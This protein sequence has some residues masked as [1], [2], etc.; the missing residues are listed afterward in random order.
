MRSFE[1]GQPGSR[2][3]GAESPLRSRKN[4]RYRTHLIDRAMG[5]PRAGVPRQPSHANSQPSEL[6]PWGFSR[7]RVRA[8]PRLT[9]LRRDNQNA[10]TYRQD[11]VR[12]WATSRG[13]GVRS[14][15]LTPAAAAAPVRP[16]G[17]TC[18]TRPLTSALSHQGRGESTRSPRRPMARSHEVFRRQG[19][20]VLRLG[21]PPIGPP[22]PS[23]AA[24][25][26]AFVRSHTP[27]PDRD[28]RPARPLP[29]AM[30][31]ARPHCRRAA[32]SS[33]P[34]RPPPAQIR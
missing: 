24:C 9:Q 12:N 4:R 10:S 13:P 34:H 18:T 20:Q 30:S 33:R 11:V 6:G 1:D 17:G 25:P 32:G 21:H 15:R 5:V 22:R 7:P 29:P 27:F 31:T 26:S 28:R 2:K 14:R 23:H 19:R 3:E 16:A 8:L